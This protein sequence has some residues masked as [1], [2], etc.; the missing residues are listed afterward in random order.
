MEMLIP[1]IMKA[2]RFPSGWLAEKL[3]CSAGF[4][5][6]HSGQVYQQT[7]KAV[8]ARAPIGAVGSSEC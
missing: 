8:I 5:E 7:Q 4:A 6:L 2:S 1:G 3:S